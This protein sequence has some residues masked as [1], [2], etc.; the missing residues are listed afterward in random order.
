MRRSRRLLAGVLSLLF[1]LSGTGFAATGAW[2]QGNPSPADSDS[3]IPRPINPDSLRDSTG[4]DTT[5]THP[6]PMHPKPHSSKHHKP[7]KH[8]AKPDTSNTSH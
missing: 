3:S 1:A 2:A 8:P 5:G 4:T 6:H 7:P